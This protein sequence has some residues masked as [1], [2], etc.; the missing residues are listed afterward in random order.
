MKIDTKKCTLIRKDV[1][2]AGMLRPNKY[3]FGD[4]Q[5]PASDGLGREKNYLPTM[6]FTPVLT[7]K[8]NLERSRTLSSA[9]V[10]EINKK[11]SEMILG[12]KEEED[13]D[14]S[15]SDA[16]ENVQEPPAPLLGRIYQ[17][18]FNYKTNKS[19]RVL[20]STRITKK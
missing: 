1:P 18:V 2:E 14:E 10:D 9:E 13:D 19:S 4:D 7:S 12:D 15:D 6:I 5:A 20:R 11:L 17:T 16:S 8:R 3:I